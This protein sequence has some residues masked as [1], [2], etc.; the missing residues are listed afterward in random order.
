M[1]KK[2]VYEGPRSSFLLVKC[3]NCGNEQVVFSHVS[4]KVNCK[5]CN[6]ILAEP[7]GGRSIIRGQVTRDLK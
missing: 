5:I 6:T 2:P 1:P 3:T 7:S 4:S